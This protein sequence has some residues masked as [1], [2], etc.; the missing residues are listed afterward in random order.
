[1]C[2]VSIVCAGLNP[3]GMN[4]IFLSIFLFPLDFNMSEGKGHNIQLP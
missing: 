4:L 1:M 3:E 2:R